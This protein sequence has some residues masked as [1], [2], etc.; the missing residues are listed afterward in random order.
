M[1]AYFTASIVGKK[2][3][4]ADYIAIVQ[5]LKKLNYTVT[6]D[7]ILKTK[8][9]DMGFETSKERQIFHKKLE[10]WIRT[11]DIFV[12]N[13]SFPSISVGYE[14][15]MA[16]H[17]NKPILLLHHTSV[18]APSLLIDYKA[19]EVIC[20]AYTRESLPEIIA[21]FVNYAKSKAESR[22]TFFIT[23]EI[24]LY[25]NKVAKKNKTP[26]SVYLRHLIE[27]DMKK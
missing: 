18:G 15:S 8:P 7:H 27:E 22:F 26:K 6:A 12:A 1:K 24:S 3:Y 25:L 20:E 16:L 23:P 14:I 19:D 17:F 21:D 2:L 10:A 5:A 9:E 4:Y 13:T 11:S